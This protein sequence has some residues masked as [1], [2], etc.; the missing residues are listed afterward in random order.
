MIRYASAL[1]APLLVVACGEDPGGTNTD[2]GMTTNTADATVAGNL[3]A[4]NYD[5]VTQELV[6][7]MRAIHGN[8]TNVT[9]VRRADLDASVPGYEVY[10]LQTTPADRHYTAV[11]AESNDSHVIAGAVMDGGNNNQFFGGSFYGRQGL[12]VYSPYTE[13]RRGEA[14]YY[15][16]YAGVTNLD[17]NGDQLLDQSGLPSG[18]TGPSQSDRITGKIE[19]NVNFKEGL[20]DGEIF[21]R[22]LVDD[23]QGIGALPVI[24][25]KDGTITAEGTFVGVAEYL[26]VENAQIGSFGGIFGGSQ[27]SSVAGTVY[28]EEYDGTTGTISNEAEYGVFVLTRCGAAGADPDC[29]TN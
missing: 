12:D 3:R 21:N 17:S 25:L 19:L 7:S 27:A 15:G 1:L 26:T 20:L 14:Q 8:Q 11:F 6:L 13:T 23:V 5:P 2:F 29:G 28:L 16:T 22:T 10:M 24:A 18:S 9:Y 4:V